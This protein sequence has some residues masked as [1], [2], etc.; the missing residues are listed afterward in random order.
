MNIYFKAKLYLYVT[1]KHL[2]FPCYFKTWVESDWHRII[3][4][5]EP[6]FSA[7]IFHAIL[8]LSAWFGKG[9]FVTIITVQSYW[10][11]V[12]ITQWW[13]RSVSGQSVTANKKNYYFLT[14]TDPNLRP[15]SVSITFVWHFRSVTFGW[16]KKYEKMKL[17]WPKL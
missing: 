6:D 15:L 3:F 2:Y 16:R 4:C 14:M 9:N 8:H 7:E 10:L 12:I 17:C 11:E 1:V 13:I 5:I